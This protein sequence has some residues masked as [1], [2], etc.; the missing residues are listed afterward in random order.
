MPVGDIV[1]ARKAAQ[2]LVNAGRLEPGD[3]VGLFTASRNVTLDFTGDAEKLAASLAQL[4]THLNTPDEGPASCPPMMPYQAHQIMNVHD[5]QALDLGIEQG[6]A[7]LCLVG[8]R[9]SEQALMVQRRADQVLSM[10]EQFGSATLETLGQV[11]THLSQKPGRRVLVLV[12]SG[13]LST[14]L[15]HQMDQLVEAA[16][17]SDIVINSLDAKG[18]VTDVSVGVALRPTGRIRG[19]LMA[20]ADALRAQ[21]REVFN[22]LMASLSRDTGGIFFHNN[23]DLD[24]G[25]R[26]ALATPEARYVLSFSPQGLKPDGRLHNLSVKLTTPSSFSVDARRGYFAP[27]KKQQQPAQSSGLGALDSAV[28]AT[29]R[30]SDL[31][32]DASVQL[33]KLETGEPVLR[34]TIHVDVSKLPFQHRA[35]RSLER[36]RLVTVLFDA[37]G[38]FLQGAEAM[39]DLALKDATLAQLAGHGFTQK[40]SLRVPA[41]SYNL[42]EVVQEDVQGRIAAVSHP[43][44]IP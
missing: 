1:P 19:D 7:A 29:G 33:E 34:V 8:L 10:A 23:N 39:I 17:R 13:F 32:A 42:R 26:K 15:Q 38:K 2:A 9:R 14:T 35:D 37:E 11:V 20:Y 6:V 12:S 36:L 22:D 31:P 28:S 21:Q 44:Q 18:L 40:L 30:I 27:T 5:D 41:G 3:R 25:F 4:R 16:L 43:V 24:K